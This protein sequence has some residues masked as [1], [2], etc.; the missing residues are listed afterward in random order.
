M[1]EASGRSV[2]AETH[3]VKRFKRSAAGDDEQLPS[4]IRTLPS[5]R[6]T[7]DYLFNEVIAGDAALASVHKFVWDRS[8]SVR[9]DFSIQQVSK[10]EDVKIAVECF[11][12]IARFHILSLHQLSNPENIEGEQFDAHQ[13][14][15]QLNNTMLSLMYYY[16]DYR[17]IINFPNESE[18]RAYL[19][20]FELQALQPD[21]DDRLQSW[22]VD[23]LEN[24]RVKT[25]YSLYAAASNTVFEQGPLRPLAPFAVA[26]SNAGSFWTLLCSGAVSYLMGCVAEMYFAQVRF[27]ALNNLWKS[28]K[29]AST[30]QQSKN[31][32]WT[33]SEL[34]SFLGFDTE[35]AAQ[36]FCETFGLRLGENEHGEKYL[37]ATV[38]LSALN[39]MS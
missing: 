1:D 10:H 33:L 3:M 14:R 4:D 32:D 20:L 9:N 15:E 35:T 27:N 7:L 18:F 17:D 21:L 36:N 26:Q 34:T 11:E 23:M 6:R 12:R 2:V 24:G 38:A 22:P 13:D 19:V 16:N 8:R 28:I 29:G 5:L 25:A 37:D 39:S 31:K 30:G